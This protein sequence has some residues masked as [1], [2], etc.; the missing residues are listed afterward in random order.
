MYR[1]PAALDNV[2]G[3]PSKHSSLIFEQQFY[4]D[5][6]ILVFEFFG[7]SPWPTLYKVST[8]HGKR[9]IVQTASRLLAFHRNSEC[10]Y[11]LITQELGIVAGAAVFGSILE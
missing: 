3:R 4:L 7:S 5:V 11:E 2:R 6:C 8:C 9:R 10:L 1:A